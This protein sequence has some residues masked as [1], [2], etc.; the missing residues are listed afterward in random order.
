MAKYTK[1]SLWVGV[2]YGIIDNIDRTRYKK[3]I[4]SC[5]LDQGQKVMYSMYALGGL[6]SMY[7]MT[8]CRLYHGSIVKRG[9]KV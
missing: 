4:N 5:E 9:F 1:Y 3:S 8:F 2:V 6:A 7:Y